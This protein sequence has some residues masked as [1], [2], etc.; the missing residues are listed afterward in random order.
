M[1]LPIPGS[2]DEITPEWLTAAL[3]SSG[4]LRAAQVTGFEREPIGAG[5]GLLGELARLTLSYDAVEAGAPAT[6]I[7]K[8]PTQD[9]GGRGLAHMLGFYEN[10]ERYY[11]EM[12][13]LNPI[14]SPRCYYGAGDP[15]TVQFVLLL[16][17]LAALRM[18]DQLAGLTLAEAKVA[19]GEFA[20]YHAR[21]WDTPEGPQ[22]D[23]IPGFDHPRWQGLE[24][25]YPG[26]KDVFLARFGHLLEPRDREVVEGFG[27]QMVDVLRGL[28][29]D[30]LTIGHGDARM[31]NFFFGSTDGSAPMTIIDWQILLRAPG[32]YDIGYMLAQSIDSELRR[33]HERDLLRQYHAALVAGGVDCYSW[34]RCWEDY[35]RVLLFCLVY[36]VFGGGAIEP[37]NER[38]AQLVEALTRRAFAAI[39]DLDCY[40]LLP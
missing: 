1:A 39:R 12:Q 19:V 2:I 26:A 22:V 6:L 40:E 32:T 23:W 24:M 33:D 13:P 34:E 31:D 29:A 15:A 35:R 20:R 17:D 28:D 4:T 21:F 16:E 8:M 3:Q 7:A 10:E 11:R 14:H 37:A 36:P 38:G 18:G 9:P 30:R 5:V 25:A 27:P